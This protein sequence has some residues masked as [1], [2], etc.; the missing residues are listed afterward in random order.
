MGIQSVTETRPQAPAPPVPAGASGVAAPAQGEKKAAPQPAPVPAAAPPPPPPP[1]PAKGFNVDIEVGFH[2][3]T[4][5]RVYSFV[6]PDSGTTL[7]QIPISSVLD[8]VAKLV[9]QME[10]EGQR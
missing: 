10:A 1:P 4:N 2:E 5:T 8:M 7:V 9:H 3:A 6:D